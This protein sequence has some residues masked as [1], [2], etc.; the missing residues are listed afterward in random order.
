[1]YRY[2]T[3]PSAA[4]SKSDWVLFQMTHRTRIKEGKKRVKEQSQ[5]LGKLTVLSGELNAFLKAG[6]FFMKIRKDDT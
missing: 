3:N 4:V 5:G 6:D 1:M 2:S